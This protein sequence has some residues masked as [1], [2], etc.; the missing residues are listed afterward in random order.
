MS[1]DDE[2][3]ILLRAFL[4]FNG[5]ALVSHHRLCGFLRM[6]MRFTNGAVNQSIA[7][8]HSIKLRGNS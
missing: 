7:E 2:A 6:Y 8:I 3:H 4:S 5:F 1:I